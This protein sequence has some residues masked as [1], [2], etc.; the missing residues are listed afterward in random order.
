MNNEAKP[1]PCETPGCQATTEHDGTTSIWIDEN[2]KQ[3]H[4]CQTCIKKIIEENSKN[5]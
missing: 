5:L 4:L 1:I 2:G 3:R